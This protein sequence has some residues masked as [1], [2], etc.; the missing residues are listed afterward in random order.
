LLAWLSNGVPGQDGSGGSTGDDITLEY[1]SSV[2]LIVDN[3]SSG[4]VRKVDRLS[5][6]SRCD[7]LVAGLDTS[8]SSSDSKGLRIFERKRDFDFVH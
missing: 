5:G 1:P 8:P 6:I 7:V 4:G 2:T 3:R